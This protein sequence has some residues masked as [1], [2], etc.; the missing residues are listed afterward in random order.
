MKK[1]IKFF[2]P[3]ALLVFSLVFIAG[4]SKDEEDTGKYF[5]RFKSNGEWV[6][7]TNQLHQTAG[8]VKSGLQHVGTISGMNDATSNF[9]I[10]IYDLEPITEGTYSGYTTSVEGLT[11]IL[12]AHKDK[13]TGA[14]YGSAVVGELTARLTIT[15][16]T[17]TSVS[18]TFS[19][20]LKSNDHPDIDI[21][22]GSF[23]V[24]RVF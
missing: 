1:A 2:L 7:Y 23:F 14:V 21:T 9:S 20:V 8:F 10:L 5:M 15:E 18:G 11:G 4:C 19:G 13:S 17:E 3:F 22:E 12:L 16:M 6:E 24:K